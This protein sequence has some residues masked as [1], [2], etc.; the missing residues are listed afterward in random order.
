[1]LYIY[2]YDTTVYLTKPYYQYHYIPLI[3]ISKLINTKHFKGTQIYQAIDLKI[4][5]S[6]LLYLDYQTNPII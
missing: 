1:M 3:I 5:I 6:Q 2:L 4:S